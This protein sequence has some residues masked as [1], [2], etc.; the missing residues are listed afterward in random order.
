MA[1]VPLAGVAAAPGSTAA[2]PQLTAL[3]LPRGVTDLVIDPSHTATLYAAVPGLRRPVFKSTDGGA[4]WTNSSTGLPRGAAIAALAIDPTA[5]AATV[6]A[7]TS[8][9]LFV[10]ADG[11]ATW[12]PVNSQGLPAGVPLSTVTVSPATSPPTLYLG[13]FG[14]GVFALAPDS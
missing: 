6:Y 2:Q 13:T 7:S 11:A 1:G 3:P 12:Q 14:A 4:T 8:Q 9:G 5:P 10:T